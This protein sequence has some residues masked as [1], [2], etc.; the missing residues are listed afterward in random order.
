MEKF[1]FKQFSVRNEDSAMKVGTDAVLLG[2][3]MTLPAEGGRL[4]DIGTGTGVIALIAAQRLSSCPGLSIRAAHSSA[5]LP[6]RSF[7][8]TAIDIDPA[9]A[10]EAASNFAS[11]PWATHL[12]AHNLSL[13]GFAAGA[14]P[15]GPALFDSI[16]SNPPYFEESLRNPD[17]REAAARHNSSL[18]YRDIIAYASCHLNP[19]GILSLIL[20]AEVETA[21]GRCASSFGLRMFRILR[22]RGTTR[23]PCSRIIAEFRPSDSPLPLK[24]DT[25]TLMED[26]SRSAAYAALTEELYLC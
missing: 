3:A 8:I 20:P 5:T 10:A 24:E 16:F 22:I 4:L 21:L 11:S 17:P 6:S 15:D 1:H 14:G 25:L 12:A 7:R 23:K 2:A 26:G 13:A 18:S 9:S 19:G